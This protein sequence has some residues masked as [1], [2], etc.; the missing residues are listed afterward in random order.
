MGFSCG[1]WN[2]VLVSH[3]H[4]L[5]LPLPILLEEQQQRVCAIASSEPCCKRWDQIPLKRGWT[6][7]KLS[8]SSSLNFKFTELLPSERD[9]EKEHGGSR[10][11][12]LTLTTPPLE[13]SSEVVT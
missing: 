7:A 9:A 10:Y 13:D 3:S 12:F 6:I 4:P 11:A 2:G 1:S 8:L 5:F